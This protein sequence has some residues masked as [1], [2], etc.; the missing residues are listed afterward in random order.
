MSDSGSQFKSYN[1]EIPKKR[2][3]T[4]SLFSIPNLAIQ[5]ILFDIGYRLEK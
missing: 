3:E 5:L 2:L 4:R 1:V